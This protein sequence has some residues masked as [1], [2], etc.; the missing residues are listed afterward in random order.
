MSVKRDFFAEQVVS[1]SK[2][3][4]HSWGSCPFAHPGEWASRRCP[5]KTP[6]LPVLCPDFSQDGICTRVS[7]ISPGTLIKYTSCLTSSKGLQARG[8]CC[9][10]MSMCKYLSGPWNTRRF[11][12]YLQLF[13]DML[14]WRG[15]LRL[16]RLSCT[17]RLLPLCAW[18]ERAGLPPLV[19]P[20]PNV[21][22][23]GALQVVPVLLF[24]PD[25]PAASASAAAAA[26]FAAQAPAGVCCIGGSYVG[27]MGAPCLRHFSSPRSGH[28][29]TVC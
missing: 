29:Q 6:Y 16:A 15:L 1:C 27:L 22:L 5:S 9:A 14:R 19:L 18:H 7:L 23:H 12:G 24:A 11:T 20:N 4:G 21:P 28:D 3:C 10:A 8:L 26:G 17:G 13:T 25:Q 2:V